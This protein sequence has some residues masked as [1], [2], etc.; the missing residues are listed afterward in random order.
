MNHLPIA[1]LG[2]IGLLTM[3]ITG[4]QGGGK[5]LHWFYRMMIVFFFL[6]VLLLFYLGHH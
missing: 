1:I 6:M 2:V 3:A 4:K 5:S